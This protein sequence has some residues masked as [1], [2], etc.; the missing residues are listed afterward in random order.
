MPQREHTIHGG[1]T[2]MVKHELPQE[3][4]HELPQESEHELPQESE[5]EWPYNY[6]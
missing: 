5:R 1:N 6:P 2:W 4:E 3:S